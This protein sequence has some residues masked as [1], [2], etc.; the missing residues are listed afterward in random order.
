MS[1]YKLKCQDGQWHL[2]HLL[3]LLPKALVSKMK[4]T[5]SF[6]VHTASMDLTLLWHVSCEAGH[7]E[8]PAGTFRCHGW[9]VSSE[10]QTWLSQTL[11]L[12][13]LCWKD[14]KCHLYLERFYKKRRVTAFCL[15][16][17]ATVMNIWFWWYWFFP[18]ATLR[19]S[20]L[21]APPAPASLSLC[22]RGISWSLEAVEESGGIMMIWENLHHPSCHRG[23][24]HSSNAQG[25]LWINAALLQL[26]LFH[27]ASQWASWA[28]KF[29]SAL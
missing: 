1:N 3:W 7:L 27:Q 9:T 8:M 13:L 17:V 5:M 2:S 20:H 19:F 21:V 11:Q 26:L 16:F 4:N 6:L 29:L 25:A 18:L 22:G 28:T 23:P 24:E 10:N 15:V 14:Y 12:F